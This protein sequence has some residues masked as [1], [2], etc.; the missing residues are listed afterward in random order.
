MNKYQ[1]EINKTTNKEAKVMIWREIEDSR[2]VVKKMVKR[3]L[4]KYSIEEL[5]QFRREC[6]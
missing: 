5:R 6:Y 1:R 3:V 4:N 2:Y